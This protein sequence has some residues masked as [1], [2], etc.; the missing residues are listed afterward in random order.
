MRTS[1]SRATTRYA[2]GAAPVTPRLRPSRQSRTTP[3]LTWSPCAPP[4]LALQTLADVLIQELFRARLTER[5]P[6]LDGSV[7]GEESNTIAGVSAGQAGGAE[8]EVKE[9]VTIKICDDPAQT[10]ALLA[11]ALPDSELGR[12]V[13]RRLA[14]ICAK[15]AALGQQ[16]AR[17]DGA[18]TGGSE[19]G[20]ASCD[21]EDAGA[22]AALMRDGLFGVHA[23]VSSLG[24]W[25]DPL[26][27]T[28]EFIGEQADDVRCDAASGVYPGGLPVVTVLV[29]VY[30][31][32]SGVPLAGV[33]NQPFWRKT[34]AHGA[35]AGAM[36]ADA[37]AGGGVH[38]SACAGTGAWQGRHFWG[39]SLRDGVKSHSEMPTL[40]AEAPGAA[41]AVDAAAAGGRTTALVSVA[42]SS[43]SAPLRR[44]LSALGALHTPA[45]AGYKLL[46]VVTGLADAYV[47]SKSST[48]KWDTCAPHAI[49][50]AIGGVACTYRRLPLSSAATG[51]DGKEK[52]GRAAAGPAAIDAVSCAKDVQC[53]CA[54]QVLYHHQDHG[55]DSWKNS[56]G[57]VMCGSRLACDDA[58]FARVHASIATAAAAL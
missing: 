54:R 7:G 42:S 36:G 20:A 40:A 25:I 8:K 16:Q 30:D 38:A 48:Y 49:L 35:G 15:T 19:S 6:A 1:A 21:A 13:A 10:A 14:E 43:E 28:N 3:S 58:L 41:A 37:G 39:I 2:P 9:D 12:G 52:G 53:D 56:A 33:V 24:F 57:L 51:D 18:A 50:N 5:Y 27:G 31:K 22:R 45:G 11:R 55:T 47:L 23:P 26:D 44:E 34:A 29:G 32:T 4:P 46:C 17:D